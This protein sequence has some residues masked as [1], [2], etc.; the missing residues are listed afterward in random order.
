VALT[1]VLAGLA[2]WLRSHRDFG[3]GLIAPRAGP[4][5]GSAALGRPFGLATRI[6]RGTVF[7]WAVAVAL[8]GIAYGS[9]A[10][11]IEE[12][13]ADNEAMADMM[14][15]ATGASL[16]DAYLAMSMLILAIITGGAAIQMTLRLRS[17]ESAGRAEPMLATPTSR[18]G[19]MGSHLAVALGGSAAVMAAGGL[20]TG[21]TYALVIGDAGQ[22]P[23]LIGAALVQVPAVWVLVGIAC[24]LFGLIPRWS[25]AAWAVLALA[26]V[27]AMFG[28]LLDLPSAVMDLSPFQHT[29]QGPAHDPTALPL[30]VML[31]VG[32]GLTAVGIAGFRRR[33][34]G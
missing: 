20:G 6:Q 33:D 18:T 32:A 16:T 5:H 26:L 12:F 9:I 22:V 2:A 10:N 14:A 23:R 7:W 17:E 1:A 31:A 29:P 13:V 15:S 19:W 30:V 3:S 28:A 25:I 27:V 34:V 24:A 4:A 11:S 21:V 8:T